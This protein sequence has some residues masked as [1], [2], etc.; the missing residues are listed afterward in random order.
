MN[1]RARR[2]VVAIS[3]AGVTGSLTLTGGVASAS[4]TKGSPQPELKAFTVASKDFN[5]GGSVAILPSGTLLAAFNLPTADNRGETKICILPRSGR[6]CLK[7]SPIIIPPHGASNTTTGIP[8]VVVL[9]S[10]DV[11][12]LIDDSTSGDLLYSSTDAGRSFGSSPISVGNTS[13]PLIGV[14]ESALIGK[15]LVFGQT[16]GASGAQV[17]SVSLDSPAAPST[18]ATASSDEAAAIGIGFYKGGALVANGTFSPSVVMSYAKAGKNLGATSSYAKVGTFTHEN[19]IGMSGP[20]LLTQGTTG[21]FPVRLRVF[22]GTKFG[23]AHTVPHASSPGPEEY[24]VDRDPSGEIHVF[25]ILAATGYELQEQSSSNGAHWSPRRTLA[26]GESSGTVDGALD[27]TGSGIIL[28]TNADGGV[29]KAYPVLASQTVSFSLSKST[30]K[31]GAKVKATGKAR[32]IKKGRTI[33]LEKLEHGLWHSV[34]T[35]KE[36]KTGAFSFTIKAS[37]VGSFTYRAVGS[38]TA[39]FVEF[40]YSAGRA[41]HVKK[42]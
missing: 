34:T 29:A 19:L 25:T 31:A 40:G 41:L 4:V 10:K 13:G 32:P 33:T 1:I 35:T 37:S 38:D 20:V 3:V 36:S 5:S 27:A 16:Q 28:G 15:D 17:L 23:V 6:A 21:S 8:Q 18:P 39:G 7:S 22:N 9:S 14:D 26:N 12:V 30:V 42:K 11:D 24:V 2:L